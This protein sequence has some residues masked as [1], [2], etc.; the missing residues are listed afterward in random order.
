M[1]LNTIEEGDNYYTWFGYVRQSVDE[2]QFATLSLDY[3][4]FF[5][6][7]KDKGLS[8]F[9]YTTNFVLLGCSSRKTQ[10]KSRLILIVYSSEIQTF[11]PNIWFYRVS[12]K[13]SIMDI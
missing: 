12:S 5:S 7:Q 11:W 1:F 10:N 3:N 2:R 9:C 13:K 8:D 4:L 6:I